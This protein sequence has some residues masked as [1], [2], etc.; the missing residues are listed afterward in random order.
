MIE[1]W[2]DAVV[3]QIYPRSFADRNGDGEG[4]LPG[5]IDRLPYLSELGVDAVWL[6]PFYPSPMRD[7]GYDISDYFDIDPRFGTLE[8]FDLL[9]TQARK[10]DIRII[11]DIVPNHCSDQHPWFR[12]ALSAPIGSPLR[13]RFIFRDTVNNWRSHFGGSAWTRTPDGQYYLHLFDSTQPDFNWGNDEVVQLFERYLR[14][15]LDRGVAAVRIDMANTLFKMPGLPDAEDGSAGQPYYDQPELHELYRAWR[16]I[17]DSYPADIFPG[18]RGAVAE[19]WFDDP[20][21]VRPYLAPDELP[22]VFNFRLMRVSWTAQ[23]LRQVIDE[24]R[25]LAGATGG[26]LPWA[27]GNHDVTRLV[28]RLGLPQ[29]PGEDPTQAIR[30]GARHTDIALGTRRARS[31]AL[32]L[33]ALP[34]SVYLY[35]GDELGLPEHLDLPP[36]RREDPTYHRTEGVDIGRDG[37]RIPLPW[38]GAAAPYGFTA[39][40]ATTWLPQP[41]DWAELTVENQSTRSDSMLALY[42]SALR[43]RHEHPALGEGALNWLELGPQVL[44]FTR[45]PGFTFVGNLGTQPVPLPEGRVLLS[46]TPLDAGL[47]PGDA[48][49]WLHRG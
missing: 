19:I 33:L 44:A 22:Q 30:L 10:Q 16:E 37:C 1:W 28:S 31:A 40:T 42:R 4:D 13:D 5:L 47:L 8:D 32:L 39:P 21:M 29:R 20:A 18:R 2:R 7:G 45:E 25:E 41:S 12:A 15:W 27:L 49:A 48:A 43:I 3:Y 24:G 36:D 38:S 11:I 35:Q 46:T 6:S 26:S 14:F 9:V 23:D 17:L 34:G